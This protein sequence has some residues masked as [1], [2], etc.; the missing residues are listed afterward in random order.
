[1]LPGCYYFIL[2]NDN[3]TRQK[4]RYRLKYC[5]K[6]PLNPKQPTNKPPAKTY[7]PNFISA[8]L[9]W[10]ISDHT[11]F[12]IEGRNASLHVVSAEINFSVKIDQM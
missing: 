12:V 10:C 1:M 6:G 11:A 4:A 5:L 2:P 3:L 8:Q 9:F 7:K